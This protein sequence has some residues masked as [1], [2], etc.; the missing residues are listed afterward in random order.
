MDKVSGLPTWHATS[1][2]PALLKAAIDDRFRTQLGVAVLGEGS[3]VERDAKTV[4]ARLIRNGVQVIRTKIRFEAE[5]AV[6]G[7][8]ELSTDDVDI[9]E[10]HSYEVRV[11]EQVFPTSVTFK[12][13]VAMAYDN[14]AQ[15]NLTLGMSETT[16]EF[17]GAL[18][19]ALA[20]GNRP[21]E[22]DG[23]MSVPAPLS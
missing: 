22:D 1:V 6:K 15:V 23:F 7:E 19:M 11:G 12:R 8:S 14:Y 18:L 20:E 16:I 2:T 21:H 10:V 17:V 3:A 9:F 13:G 4:A 5:L